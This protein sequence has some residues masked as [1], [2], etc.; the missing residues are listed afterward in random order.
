MRS[1]SKLNS[2]D[3]HP[4]TIKQVSKGHPWI[5]ADKFTEKFNPRDNF[6]V[7]LNNKRPF[8]LFLHDPLHPQ[9]KAR[10]W[11]KE[12]NFEKQVRNFKTDLA[13]RIHDS[14]QHRR[15]LKVL[16]QRENIYLIFGEADKL[17][18]MNVQ[19][20][21]DQL[22]FQFYG[23]FWEQYQGHII[24]TTL[25][26]VRK[27]LNK[28][29]NK[30]GVWVQTRQ[31][32]EKNQKFPKSL[33]PNLTQKQFAIEEFGVKYQLQL[34]NSYDIGIY[35]DMAAIRDELRND[36]LK[37]ESVLNLYSYTGAFSLFALKNQ[38]N[39]VVSVDLSKKYL[40]HLDLNI[41]LNEIG[42][43]TH[44]CV[45]K[46]SLKALEDMD[47]QQFDLIVCD[48]PSSSNDGKKRSNALKD[49]QQLIPQMV[50]V[51]KNK[52]KLVLFLNTHRTARHK[53]EQ[54]IKQI[55]DE[56]PSQKLQIV[57]KLRLNSDCPT[58]KGFPEGDYLKGLVIQKND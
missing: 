50:R 40:D 20:L 48:P 31:T 7:G 56:Q 13:A 19:L 18:G 5:L 45:C 33:N 25:A 30:E 8:A 52:G 6:I 49:Y 46:S 2:Y 44:T 17:P 34:G 14:I 42:S 28:A 10:L 51:L 29:V 27:L 4:I 41:E 39:K 24:E 57:K 1:Y 22:L 11:S 38:A 54:K 32:G 26:S 53:F 23:H 9:V 15:D 55:L 16:E 21:G 58:L 12:G 37:A 36:F 47:Q 35:T 43:A 3:I